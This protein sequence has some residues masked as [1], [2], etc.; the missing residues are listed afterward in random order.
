MKRLSLLLVL[1]LACRDAA[2]PPPPPPGPIPVHAEAFTLREIPSDSL[3]WRWSCCGSTSGYPIDS[4]G[5]PY[6][7]VNGAVSYHPAYI[8]QNALVYE[9]S[10]EKSGKP[11]FLAGLKNWTSAVLQRSD[12]LEEGEVFPRYDFSYAI[13]ADPANNL[14]VGWHSGFTQGMLLSLLVRAAR[15]T[16]DPA[17]ADAADRVFRGLTDT[18]SRRV[19]H[20]D[21]AGYYWIDEYPIPGHPDLTL[22]GFAYAVRGLYEY[23]QLKKTP[24]SELLLREALT[25]LKHYAP[26]YRRVGLPSVYCLAHRVPAPAYH[27]QD[28]ELLRDMYRMTGDSAFAQIADDF[29]SD[30]TPSG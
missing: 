14:P 7:I 4:S 11:V 27:G 1:A 26:E 17:Y 29:A 21:S 3:W 5:V 16:N 25:T 20:V 8:T 30:F 24:E 22:N 15:V 9:D 6:L 13:H 19:A 23:W 2:A 18:A 10:W 28:I 12:T